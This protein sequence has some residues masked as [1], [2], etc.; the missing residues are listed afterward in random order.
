MIKTCDICGKT[1]ETK[2]NTN[3]CS[4][5]CRKEHKKAMDRM[6]Q[7]SHRDRQPKVEKLK[8]C[9]VCGKTFIPRNNSQ[10]YC[11]KQC[12]G[13]VVSKTVRIAKCEVCGKK[14][15][16]MYSQTLC[17]DE[18]RLIRRKENVARSNAAYKSRMREERAKEREQERKKSVSFKHK[19][20]EE[21]VRLLGDGESYGY[22]VG[23]RHARGERV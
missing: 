3:V 23:L 10:K 8:E 17:S 2:T 13:R 20:I 15:E 9:R 22:Y 16:A 21:V 5:E 7:Q 12:S 1:F 19:S 11:S 4:D 6:H 14:F 18:C